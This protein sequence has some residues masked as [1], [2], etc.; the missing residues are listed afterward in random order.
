LFQ[1]ARIPAEIKLSFARGQELRYC[2]P[3]KVRKIMKRAAIL[4]AVLCCVCAS[5]DTV[6]LKDGTAI[7]A[8]KAVYKG[9]QVEYIVGITTYRIPASQVER[10]E[11]TQSFGV[12]VSTVGPEGGA[13][14][15]PESRQTEA[16]PRAA[17]QQSI[18]RAPSRISI[19]VN[20]GDA[21][22]NRILING[23]IET[24]A[25]QAIESEGN[26]RACA[27]AY[28]VAA[29]YEYGE[30]NDPD[31]ARA[32][33][34]RAIDFA[35]NDPMLLSW[36]S[37]LLI[38]AGDYA[39]AISRAEQAATI[40]PD[41]PD[42]FRQ[43]GTAYY[44][45]NRLPEAIK[46]W[47]RSLVLRPDDNLR[48]L[49][50]K[51]EREVA[52]EGEFKEQESSHFTVRFEGQRTG[53]TLASDVLRTLERQYAELSRDLNYS[54]QQS[55]SV[56][57][58]TEKEF[59]DVTQSPSWSAGAN[60]GKL[61]IPVKNLTSVG[62]QFER[63]LKHEL[64]HSFVHFMTRGNCPAWLNEG[65]AQLMEGRD[66]NYYAPAI[67]RLYRD[68]KFVPLGSLHEAFSP[69]NEEKADIAYGESLVMVAYLES[70]YGMPVVL[71]ILEQ[72][73]AGEPAENAV[74]EITQKD[75]AQLERD[76][77]EALSSRYKGE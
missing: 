53:F 15:D 67:A 44:V 70:T 28:A 24:R 7:K 43:L 71:R 13:F 33:A 51:V 32:Y 3:K 63:V 77:G 21:M 50:A 76:L 27:V 2:S 68:G 38:D 39:E 64:T 48:Q 66:P 16:G 30:G 31:R 59:F 55:I 11:K 49:V 74:R 18:H 5:A 54:P 40:A 20:G 34:K 4:L 23:R 45:S 17:G 1:A 61:R 52:V 72:L 42:A 6:W 29:N 37:S 58:Y 9:D 65:L 10:I 14:S 56:V 46:A 8:N 25:L 47:K 35:P 57:L 19:T 26:P 69:L 12:A 75:Y 62:G 60:D 73:G 36:Y 22:L 41:S